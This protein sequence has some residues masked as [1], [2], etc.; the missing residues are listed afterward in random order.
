MT[1][2]YNTGGW[3]KDVLGGKKIKKLTIEGAWRGGGG[4]YSGLESSMV[5]STILIQRK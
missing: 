4:N 3:N 2:N 1:E 5:H